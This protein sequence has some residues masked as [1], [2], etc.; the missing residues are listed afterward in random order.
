MIFK[1]KRVSIHHQAWLFGGFFF[2]TL[3]ILV[4]S[5]ISS[6]SMSRSSNQSFML[7]LL[8]DAY[9]DAYLLSGGEF[10]Q[11]RV[12]EDFYNT[13]FIILDGKGQRLFSNAESW[14]IVKE[15]KPGI[16]KQNISKKLGGEESISLRFR[17]KNL[18]DGNQLVVGQNITALDIDHPS[19]LWVIFLILGAMTTAGIASILLGFFILRRLQRINRISQLVIDTGDLSQRIPRDGSGK[20]F[21]ALAGNLNLMLKQIQQLMGEVR[22]VSDNIAHDLRTPLTRLR[23][24][25]DLLEQSND[26]ET[27]K[28]NIIDALKN[29]ADNLLNIFSA[30]LRITN[31]ESGQ[32]HNAFKEVDLKIMLEDLYELY[33]P[34]ATEKHQQFILN[35]LP[36][37]LLA[38]SDLLFQMLANIVDNAVK[39]TPEAGRIELSMFCHEN[40]TEIHISDNGIGMHDDEFSKVFQRFYRI[41]KSRNMSGNG[42][43]LSLVAA[44]AKLHKGQILLHHN[45]PGLRVEIHLPNNKS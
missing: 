16:N 15:I 23:N 10:L 33:E 34:L 39:Y 22:Q 25:L 45:N 35:G 12:A 26:S 38:D 9:S 44:V 8:L 43:G 1:F 30:L 13:F 4:F 14:I 21:D 20:D 5:L 41:E 28:K 24:K 27:V 18:P 3:F 19:G 37:S 7:H 40:H 17:A 32:R 42:L 31:I 36:C 29:E 11:E 6:L 2:V